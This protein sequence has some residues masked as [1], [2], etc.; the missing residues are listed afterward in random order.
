MFG[1]SDAGSSKRA[2]SFRPTPA[3]PAKPAQPKPPATPPPESSPQPLSHSEPPSPPPVASPATPAEPA[4]EARA[5]PVE[6]A[7]PPPVVGEAPDAPATERV[8]PEEGHESTV[9]RSF[10]APGATGAAS[11]PKAE[12]KP[13]SQGA[14]YQPRPRPTSA[15]K[16][17]A[18]YKPKASTAKRPIAISASRSR[19][20]GLLS[21]ALILGTV[22]GV[23]ALLAIAIAGSGAIRDSSARPVMPTPIIATEPATDVLPAAVATATQTA[24]PVATATSEPS[25]SPLPTD[26]P[27]PPT[28]TPAPQPTDTP[29]AQTSAMTYTVKQGDSCWAIATRFNISVDALIRQNNLTAN[30][31]IRPGQELVIRR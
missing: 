21:L 15:S 22:L 10:S 24:P 13:R 14:A 2:I 26:T 7:S 6:P 4:D 8:T 3:Q 29:A 23:T 1:P 28:E 30:C 19:S 20:R 11:T 17:A 27:P 5:A 31:L 18:P 9:Q 25:P 12:F 16:P